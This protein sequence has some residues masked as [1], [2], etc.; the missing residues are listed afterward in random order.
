[1]LEIRPPAKA[2]QNGTVY[3]RGSRARWVRALA[4]ANLRSGGDANDGKLGSV[5]P[6][7]CCL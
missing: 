4:K 3:P 5:P 2:G 7:V 1:M 6:W